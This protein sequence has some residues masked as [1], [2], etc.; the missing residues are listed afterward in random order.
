MGEEVED[1]CEG[2]E[3]ECGGGLGLALRCMSAR[4]SGLLNTMPNRDFHLSGAQ[5]N[6]V[7]YIEERKC[8]CYI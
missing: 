7:A 5:G 6:S 4:A 8:S 1:G 3:V 2:R